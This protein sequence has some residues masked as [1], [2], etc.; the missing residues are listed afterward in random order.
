MATSLFSKMRSIYRVF[1]DLLQ[2]F[3]RQEGFV[4]QRIAVLIPCSMGVWEK[5]EC[6]NHQGLFLFAA[7]KR[8]TSHSKK[9]MRMAHKWPKN[10]NHY[11][12]CS[13]CGNPKLLHVLCGH[14]LKK[15][16]QETARVRRMREE[17]TSSSNREF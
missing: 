14:C 1:E 3:F 4:G 7:P 6:H 11:T 5:G 17:E 12:I 8:R 15:T 16:L 9:R 10:I 13:L 2:P